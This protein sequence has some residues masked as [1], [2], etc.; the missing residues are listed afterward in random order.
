[1]MQRKKTNIFFIKHCVYVG[2]LLI[3][4]FLSTLYMVNIIIFLSTLYMLLYY[5]TLE[6]CFLY[7]IKLYI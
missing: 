2:N 4:T 3:I 5:L 6:C 7:E 1:M